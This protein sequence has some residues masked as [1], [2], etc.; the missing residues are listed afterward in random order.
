[1]VSS[2][3]AG[4]LKAKVVLI[5]KDK[6]GGDCLNTGCVPSKSLIRA[7]KIAS[8]AKRADEFGFDQVK[9]DFDFAKV[10]GKIQDRIKKIEPH[11]SVER[12]QSLGVDCVRGEAKII[13]PYRIEVNEEVICTKNIILATGAAPLVPP[14]KGLDQTR[15]FTSENLW[16]LRE[17]PERFLVLGGGPIGCELAQCFSRLG[18]KVTL[19]E[20]ASHI[21]TKEDD[22]VS[23]LIQ[24]KLAGEGISFFLNHRAKEFIREG[25]QDYLVC[26][27]NGQ[28][29]KIAFD[30]VLIALG[31]KARTKGFGLQEL[32]IKVS[33]EGTIAHDSLMRTNYP[34]IY[35]CGDAAG[36]FQFTHTAAHQAWYAS[37]NALFRPLVSFKVDER[38][39]PWASFTDPE[40]ATVGLNEKQA[41]KDKIDYEV[42]RYDIS[43]LDRAI[44]DREETGFVKVLNAPGKDRILGATIVSPNAGDIIQ[45]FV[46]AMKYGLGLNKI[47]KTIH[48]YPTLVEANRFV[49]GNW[50]KSRVSIRSLNWLETFHRLRR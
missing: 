36:P 25:S 19:V 37:V 17:R 1:L 12:Y 20:A 3:I 22:D 26:D 50:R 40:V 30:A 7:A 5:E 28:E 4:T 10:M 45:E 44:T 2:L 6:M 27:N 39:I 49:A 34:N 21:L 35:V 33:K 18:S 32:E 38:V 46:I 14:F 31:R 8:M 23:N 15:F 16:Q 41:I 48:I 47:L 29:K 13:D 9:V 42:H 11:D 24:D 43:E